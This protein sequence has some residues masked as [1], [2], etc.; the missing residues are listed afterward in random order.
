M[1]FLIS[2]WFM[3]GGMSGVM[4][5]VVS[6]GGHVTNRP[7]TYFEEFMSFLV[8]SSMFWLIQIACT[9]QEKKD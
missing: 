2:R 1:S 5:M 7:L 8:M 9:L 4:V 3:F 6:V